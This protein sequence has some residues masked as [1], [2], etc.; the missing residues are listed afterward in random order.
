MLRKLSGKPPEIALPDGSIDCHIHIFD[1]KRFKH[2]KGGPNLPSDALIPH[3]EKLQKWLGME[4]VIITQANG[5]QFNNDCTLNALAHF[6]RK[7]KAIVAIPADV[8]DD[9]I[10]RMNSLGVCGARIMNILQGATGLDKMLDINARIHPFGWSLIVQFDGRDILEHIELLE[11][12]KGDYVIDHA[13]KFLEPVNVDSPS[14]IALLRLIDR[15]NCYV[16]LAGCYETSK[17]GFPDYLDVAALSKALII[18]AP[19]R[20]IWGTNW[21]HNMAVSEENYP[22]DVHLLNLINQWA[23]STENRQKIFVDNPSRLYNFN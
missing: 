6:G 11:K 10:N 4:R 9:E 22:D 7:A 12:I 1:S 3:Y 19:D 20:I 15:G 2:Q 14:F 21:P 17:T 18:H 23:G 5:Y 8:S 16:K 13:G